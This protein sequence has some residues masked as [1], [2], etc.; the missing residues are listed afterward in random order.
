MHR[1]S[2]WALSPDT[3]TVFG[4]P[5]PQFLGVELRLGDTCTEKGRLAREG[6]NPYHVKILAVHGFRVRRVLV[7]RL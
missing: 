5:L 3:G 1:V 2:E 7:P 6:R 4:A